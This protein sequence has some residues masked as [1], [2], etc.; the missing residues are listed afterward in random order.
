M[1]KKSALGKGLG[2]IFGDDVVEN[3]Q[4]IEKKNVSR[5]TSMRKNSNAEAVKEE[6]PGKEYMM[7]LSLID[8]NGE[9]PRKDFN[10]EQISELADSIKR[11]GVLQP[12]LVQKKG[13]RYEII[14]GERRWRAAKEAGIKEVPVVVREYTKQQSMEIALIE[15]VQRADLNPIEEAMAYQQL[16]QEFDLT[17]EEIAERVSKNRATIT[18][19]MRLL[20]LDKR[21]QEMLV[22]GQLSSGHARALLTLEEGEQQYQVALKIIGEKLS[23]REVEKLV[24]ALTKPKKAPKEKENEEERDLSFI[25]RDLEERMKQVMGTKVVINKRDKN[26]GKVEIEYY[27]EAELERIVELIESIR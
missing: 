13:E 17:Q 5:E 23:V 16:M 6:E 2:A 26:K 3:T 8:P 25:F 19:S 15:N 1:G 18:N 27:S 4:T 10:Q 24:K 22:Q 12:L 11:Y 20:K 21:V 14:A 7:K 9:Q